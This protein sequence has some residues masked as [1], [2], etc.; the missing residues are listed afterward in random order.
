[1]AVKALSALA[2]VVLA[3]FLL[4]SPPQSPSCSISVSAVFTR[5]RDFSLEDAAKGQWEVLQPGFTRRSLILA[6]RYMSGRRLDEAERE[7]PLRG[8]SPACQHQGRTLRSGSTRGQRPQTDSGFL[9]QRLPLASREL[10]VLH[11]LP[12]RRVHNRRD[13]AACSPGAIR[14]G[15]PRHRR[16]GSCPGPGISELLGRQ[17]SRNPTG[18]STEPTPADSG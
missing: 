3:A 12:R 14:D 4:Y 13:H 5:A 1:M 8:S 18:G 6:Y 11:E 17:A 16:L 15:Q 9:H 10:F 7:S 2:L